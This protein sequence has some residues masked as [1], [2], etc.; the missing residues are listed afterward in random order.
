MAKKK[1][2]II[3]TTEDAELRA[4]VK[5]LKRLLRQY[6]QEFDDMTAANRWVLIKKTVMILVRI[7]LQRARRDG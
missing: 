3:P 6:R 1:T 2:V 5:R 4:D 7:E